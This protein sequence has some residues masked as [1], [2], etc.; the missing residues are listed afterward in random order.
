VERC[1]QVTMK[2]F[3]TTLILI[4]LPFVPVWAQSTPSITSVANAAGGSPTIAPNTF[5]AIKGLN[6]SQPGDSRTWLASD[7]IN[8]QMPTALDGI[9]VTVNSKSAF[10]EYISPTQ[11]NI[12]TP[13]DTMPSTVPIQ[14]TNNGVVS[15]VVQVPAQPV[16]PSFF[17]VQRAVCCRDARGREFSGPDDADSWSDD[18]SET[19]RDCG[20]VR[21]RLRR[22]NAAGGERIGHANRGALAVA[23]G[24]DRWHSG[25]GAVRG[26][27]GARGVSVQRGGAV[28][29][30]ERR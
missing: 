27:G 24:D 30:T 14:V 12:L 13:P 5:V 15:A 20:V 17:F 4:C 23:R 25:A 22:D 9:S 11:I 8:N 6:L 18:A 7:F 16:S 2:I 26:A 1:F 21:H 28:E 3:G 10:V 19:G 29:C